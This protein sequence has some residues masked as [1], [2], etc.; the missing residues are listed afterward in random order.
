MDVIPIEGA[1]VV[2]TSGSSATF[3]RSSSS[4]R[5]LFT[6]L[7]TAAHDPLTLQCRQWLIV[8]SVSPL[9]PSPPPPPPPPPSPSPPLNSSPPLRSCDMS[10]EPP[11][12]R[13]MIGAAVKSTC[14]T[15]AAPSNHTTRRY[16]R[17]RTRWGRAL[18]AAPRR[19]RRSLSVRSNS[20]HNC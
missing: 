14:S 12:C 15:I 19:S 8:P 20:F 17:K 3:S 5:R 11:R 6:V 7:S 16:M 18:L 13:L 9:P 2:A 4:K 1:R 10:T